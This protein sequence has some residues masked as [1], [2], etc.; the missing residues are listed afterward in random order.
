MIWLSERN[1]S[2]TVPL[3]CPGAGGRVEPEGL[4]QIL[5]HV[6]QVPLVTTAEGDLLRGWRPSSLEASKPHPN[7]WGNDSIPQGAFGRRQPD[8]GKLARLVLKGRGAARPSLLPDRRR[9]WQ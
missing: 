8:A 2:L 7:R 6:P 4:D 1:R 9:A 5:R 3:L